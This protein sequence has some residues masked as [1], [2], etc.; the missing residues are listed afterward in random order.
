[1]GDFNGKT[2]QNLIQCG[3][4][5]GMCEETSMLAGV[6]EISVKC[7]CHPLNVGDLTGLL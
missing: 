3:R 6:L 7:G 2:N 1:M 4:I 5:I